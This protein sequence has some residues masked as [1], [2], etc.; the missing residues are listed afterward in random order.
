MSNFSDMYSNIFLH[1]NLSDYN[2]N[3]LSNIFERFSHLLSEENSKYNLTAIKNDE[4]ILPL[5]FADSLLGA[6]FIPQSSTVLDVGSGAG[7]PALP[8][9]IARNDLKITALDSTKKKTDFIKKAAAE[10]SISN[11]SVL[12]AR[13]EDLAVKPE[14]REGFDV[15]C[16][17]AV[18]RLNVLAE[19]CIPFVKKD[20]YFLAMKGASGEKEYKEAASG[21]KLLGGELV[22][23]SEKT[24]YVSP[25]ETQKRTFIL[26][27]KSHDTPALYPRSYAKITKK[28]L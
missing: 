6:E 14:F 16:A 8:L 1:N 2:N 4:S 17:R 13:A 18:S 19:L 20:G 21:I 22:S 25:S 15:V 24:L 9:S 5:H 11:I 27:K 3:F 23:L 7:F 10:L 26:I 28:P 12:T